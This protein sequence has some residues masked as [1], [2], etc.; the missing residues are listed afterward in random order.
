MI[1]R[2]LKAEWVKSRRSFTPWFLGT[3]MLLV[4]AICVLIYLN[5]WSHFIPDAGMDGWK[6]FL[7]LNL[8][9]SALL[10]P[11]WAIMS[12]ALVIHPEQKGNTWKRIFI[13]PAGK[14]ALYVGKGL[15]LYQLLTL[16][17]AGLIAAML[18]LS[19]PV[20]LLHPELNLRLSAVPVSDVLLMGLGLLVSLIALLTLQYIF[21]LLTNNVLIPTA[22]GLFLLIISLVLVQGWL[23]A[24]YDPYAFPMLFSWNV[25]GKTTMPG[26]LGISTIQWLSVPLV[27]LVAW[28]GWLRFKRL[29]V[30]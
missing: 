23:Y 22:L 28:L 10:M 3:G 20:Q 18:L 2:I 30:R 15:Y 1:N 11:V 27:L 14:K 13:T 25:S 5:R 17:V 24:K 16:T 4:P 8:G 9:M 6:P 7:H 21:S 12:V 29:P 26:W 19:V